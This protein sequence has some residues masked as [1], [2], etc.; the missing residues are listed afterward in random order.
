MPR[1]DLTAIPASNAT[2]YPAPFDAP[3]AGRLWQRLAPAGGL[4]MLGASRVVLK[5]GGWSSQRH[6]HA[7]EDELVVI[8]SGEAVLIEDAGETVVRAGDV[9]AFA[10]GVRDGHHLINRSTEDCCFIAI[11]AGNRDGA[12]EYS[13][14]DMTFTSDA[15]LHKD[16]T[17]YPTDRIR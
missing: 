8:L 6:W 9:L 16:G 10:M 3:M 13:D 17:P 12:G 15:Y 5:P 4:T 11:A 2:G 14:I 7:D 1:I